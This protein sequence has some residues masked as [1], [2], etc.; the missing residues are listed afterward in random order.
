MLLGLFGIPATTEVWIRVIGVL[1]ALL[2]VYYVQSARHELTPFFVAT[3]YTR[4]AVIVS[5]MLFVILGYAA[6]QLILFGA[7]DLAG[8]IWTW[9]ALWGVPSLSA[10]SG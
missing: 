6:P 3:I 7:V 1:V 9:T 8:A 4:V 5:F 10:A 2:C